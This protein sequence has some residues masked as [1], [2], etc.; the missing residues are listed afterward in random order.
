MHWISIDLSNIHHIC[1]IGGGT[2]HLL[3]NFLVRYPQVKGIFL[4]LESVISKREQL[5]ASKLGVSERCSYINGDMF[6]NSQ[7]PFADVCIL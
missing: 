3:G 7:I 4:E 2:G 6:S 1:D 5:L